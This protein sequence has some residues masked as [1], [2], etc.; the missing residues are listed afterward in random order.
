MKTEIKYH[1]GRCGLPVFGCH[2]KCII[3]AKAM[4][5]LLD[6]HLDR[7]RVCISQLVAVEN[8][9]FVVVLLLKKPKDLLC[10]DMGSWTVTTQPGSWLMK[11]VTWKHWENHCLK[12]H[13][14]ACTYLVRRK[15]YYLRGCP[16]FHT[17]WCLWKVCTLFAQAPLMDLLG[18]TL[19]MPKFYT[20]SG[21]GSICHSQ[22]KFM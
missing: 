11:L 19:S 15:Y 6:P 12:N 9:P 21:E 8:N 1:C 17:W 5:V 7:R 4:N 10:D 14:K 16:D 20:R 13:L 3:T 18:R 22:A 2:P